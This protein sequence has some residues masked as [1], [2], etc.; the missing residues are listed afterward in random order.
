[1]HIEKIINEVFAFPLELINDELLLRN[2]DTWDS[3]T[4]MVL[5]VKIEETFDIQLSGD[6]IVEFKSIQDIKEALRKRDKL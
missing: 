6:E 5:I 2:I 1:V 4:H 3:M